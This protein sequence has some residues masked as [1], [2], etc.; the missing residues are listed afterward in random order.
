MSFRLEPIDPEALGGRGRGYSNGILAPAGARLLFV[1]GQVGWDRERRMVE[2]G[3]AAQ[4]ERALANVVE[5]VRAAGGAP[6][7]LARVTIYV[8]DRNEYS[9]MLSAV[10]A[11]WRRVV[12]SHY[13]AMALV[14]VAGLLEPGARVE[15]EATAALPLA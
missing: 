15:I 12:G 2:G 13:P 4:F 8:V 10:G 14:E 7:H 6:E 3:F 5:V 1:A 9:A 11:A